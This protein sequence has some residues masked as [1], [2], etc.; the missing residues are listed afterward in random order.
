MHVRLPSERTKQPQAASL[1]NEHLPEEKRYARGAVEK[2]G[3]GLERF[4]FLKVRTEGGVDV[5]GHVLVPWEEGAGKSH[6]RS[7]CQP[8]A[9]IRI[10]KHVR[11]AQVGAFP[12]VYEFL[13]EFHLG[14]GDQQSALVTSEKA[15]NVFKGWGQPYMQ[16]CKL[17]QHMKG[18]E[19]EMRDAA[20]AALRTP[21]WTVALEGAD[22]DLVLGAAKSSR[23]KAQEK[24]WKLYEDERLQEIKQGKRPEQVAADRA[25]FLMD[26][27]LLGANVRTGPVWVSGWKSG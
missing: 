27:A 19:L 6:Q 2:V 1:V 14:K 21:L 15:Y 11:D 9:M 3:Y 7:F 10:N 17:L 18:R 24:F 5:Q 12:D 23:E 8:S 25:A 16:Y 4:L 20:L 26:A 22:L 13:T